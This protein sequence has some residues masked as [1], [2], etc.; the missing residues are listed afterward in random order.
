M[1]VRLSRPV[2]S[3]TPLKSHWTLVPILARSRTWTDDLHSYLCCPLWPFMALH[4]PQNMPDTTSTTFN[5][6]CLLVQVRGRCIGLLDKIA[7]YGYRL[8]ELAL[9]RARLLALFRDKR[10]YTFLLT[11]I[12]ICQQYDSMVTWTGFW[13][14]VVY[15][16]ITTAMKKMLVRCKAILTPVKVAPHEMLHCPILPDID[17]LICIIT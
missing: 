8:A 16:I 12:G 13:T 4:G 6:S 14:L 1:E 15:W 3:T 10:L 2:S 17:A 11:L 9:D 7:F 5:V